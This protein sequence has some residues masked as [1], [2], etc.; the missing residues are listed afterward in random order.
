[1][2]TRTYISSMPAGVTAP[3]VA[4]AGVVSVSQ[5]MQTIKFR[6]DFKGGRIVSV[7]AVVPINSTVTAETLTDSGIVVSVDDSKRNNYIRLASLNLMQECNI[8]IFPYDAGATGDTE[9]QIYIAG[10]GKT[11]DP[12]I[13]GSF[14]VCIH[15]II[16]EAE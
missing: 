9:L 4:L 10:K 7:T 13:S 15:F 14:P 6:D 5:V 8:P 16:E 2:R 3:V 12:T 1:M 11:L